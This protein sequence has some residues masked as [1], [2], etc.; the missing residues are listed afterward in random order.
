MTMTTNETQH[1][2]DDHEQDSNQPDEPEEREPPG[3]GPGKPINACARCGHQTIGSYA[4]MHLKKGWAEPDLY[5]SDPEE[6]DTTVVVNLCDDCHRK[7]VEMA[8]NGSTM[9][10]EFDL[11]YIEPLSEE[12]RREVVTH[13]LIALENTH[14]VNISRKKESEALLRVVTEIKHGFL[15]TSVLGEI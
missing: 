15:D 1:D 14:D 2:T 4:S 8:T 13:S 12:G 6:A 3:V 5:E 10:E 9:V 7:A 11:T